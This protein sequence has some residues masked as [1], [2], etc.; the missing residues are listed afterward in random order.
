MYTPTLTGTATA[1]WLDAAKSWSVSNPLSGSGSSEQWYSVQTVSGTISATQTTIFTYNDQLKVSFSVFGLNSDAGS[2]TVL[3][4]G[5]TNYVWNALPSNV[6]V[7]SGT[8]YSWASPVSV[9]SNDQFILTAGSSGTITASGT[10]SA[11]YQEQFKVT[12]QQG[13]LDGSATGTVVTVNGVAQAYGNLPYVTTWVNSG[14]TL[15][16]SYSN[17]VASS[18]TGKQF[19]LNSVSGSVSPI[20]VTTPTTITGNYV[21]QWLV[22][23][24]QTGLDSSA[25][26]NTVLTI[27]STNYVYNALPSGVFIDSGTNFNWASTVSGGSAKQ[28]AIT[29]SS[30]SSPIL[31]TG[32]YTA[33]YKTQYQCTFTGGNIGNDAV[34]TVLTLGSNTYTYAQLPQTN[35]WVD[36]NTGYSY[37]VTVSATAGKQYILTGTAGL[38]TPIIATGTATP[39]YKTQYDLKFA[40]TGLDGTA[41]GTIVSV[42][43]GTNPA[44]NAIFTDLTKDFGFI[45]SSTTIVYTFTSTLTSSTANKQFILTT[46]APTPI[47]GFSLGSATTVAGT[48]KTQYRLTV[49]SAHDTPTPASGSWFDASSSVTESVTTPADLSGGTQYR[50]TGW[51][52][53]SGGV[54]ATGSAAT[55]T[56]T[57]T[58]PA[59]ITWN[60]QTQYQLTVTSAHDTPTPA[61]GSWFDAS[62]SVTESVTTPADLSGGTQYRCT[63]WSTGSG[64]VPATGSAATVTFTITGP[65]SITWN[66][67]TQYLF[68]VTSAAGTS[69]GQSSGYYDAGTTISSTVSTTANVNGPPIINYTSTGYTG[70]GSAPA[71]GSTQTVAFALNT[72]S[73]VTWNWHGLMTLYPNGAGSLT[74]I[75]NISGASTHWQAV[76]DY[77]S[78]DNAQYVYASSGNTGNWTDSYTTLG[79]GSTTGSIN[80]VTV[81]VKCAQTSGSGSSAQTYLKLGSNAV[82]GASW[83]VPTAYTTN[84]NVFARPGGGFGHGAI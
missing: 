38:S 51:S 33:T 45:D 41:Q 61:S 78:A 56:F 6:W 21:T 23:F 9:S 19:R 10:T 43:I 42:T 26:S 75:P 73:S 49:T 64:G 2:N 37:T 67:Q 11:T 58:G 55:V 76:S 16:Y 7:N 71:S 22:T 59:S 40:Q 74:T 29:S 62:S 72:A 54:P 17:P 31:A 28:F 80:S 65:A 48:Y 57:I 24:S 39:T 1:Y 47:S 84:S 18:T 30:G 83:T 63:G 70:T 36:A 53:G 50:C 35:I 77:G 25:A 8:S 15:T 20:T 34:G 69:G 4:V 66:W 44:V 14:S 52:T 5:S 3:T 27:G 13:G 79:H 82:S 12:F 46:P 60:W 68:T 81:N 32:T